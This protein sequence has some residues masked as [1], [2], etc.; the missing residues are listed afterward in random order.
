[1]AKIPRSAPPASGALLGLA[2]G[3]WLPFCSGRVASPLG[4]VHSAWSCFFFF[5][6]LFFFGMPPLLSSSLAGEN[7]VPRD[8]SQSTSARCPGDLPRLGVP[9]A[10]CQSPPGP[11]LCPRTQ[12]AFS[13][14]HLFPSPTMPGN[15]SEAYFDVNGSETVFRS[16]LTFRPISGNKTSAPK[17]NVHLGHP[18]PHPL[19][20]SGV[21]YASASARLEHGPPE[22]NSWT[23]ALYTSQL[24]RVTASLCSDPCG[25]GRRSLGRAGP[26]CADRELC[27]SPFSPA[28]SVFS[29]SLFPFFLCVP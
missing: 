20:A 29:K 12:Q 24:F 9:T 15:L 26:P 22:N 13:L 8:T 10:S 17:G 16:L 27:S 18:H 6:F 3:S 7:V 4:P 2:S 21:S 23:D 25:H 1:M 5:F 19:P 11:S 28:M 14:A